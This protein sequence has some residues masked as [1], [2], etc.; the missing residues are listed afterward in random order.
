MYNELTDWKLLK[1]QLLEQAKGKVQTEVIEPSSTADQ[2]KFMILK[3]ARLKI[4]VADLDGSMPLGGLNY[5][6][7][8]CYDLVTQLDRFVASIKQG[9]YIDNADIT[10]NNT[11]KEVI[12]L[13]ESRLAYHNNRVMQ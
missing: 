3:L 1:G 5:N 9:A 11:V 13:V 10:I 8:M 6:D 4:S 7:N 12:D 2:I